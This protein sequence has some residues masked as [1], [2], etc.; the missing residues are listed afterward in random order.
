LRHSIFVCMFMPLDPVCAYLIRYRKGLT[1]KE[2]SEHCKTFD[3]AY[4]GNKTVLT[5]RLKNFSKDKSCWDK[6][7]CEYFVC[8]LFLTTNWDRLI[9]GATNAHKGS[10]KPPEEKKTKPKTS[11]LRREELFHGAAGVRVLNA[12]VTER[13]KDLRTAAEKAE[14]M[15][16][17]CN[18][19]LR[20][21][22]SQTFILLGEANYRKISLPAQCQSCGR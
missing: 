21:V 14:I 8:E 15:P 16:W 18:S 20:V 1:N 22:H 3:L 11:T 12:P 5:D 4:T 7:V 10:R 2:L 6:C 17:V 9:P 19:R 13:S